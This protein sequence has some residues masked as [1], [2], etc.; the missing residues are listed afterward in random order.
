MEA[1]C[2][3]VIGARCKASGMFGGK[4]GA[5]HVLAR[6]CIHSRRRLGLFRKDRLNS[7]AARNDNL[8]LAA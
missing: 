1:G 6:R 2:Q 7:H 5:E 4:P 8:T 3:T